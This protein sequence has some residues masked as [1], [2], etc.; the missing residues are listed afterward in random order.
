MKKR[1]FLITINWYGEVHEFWRHTSVQKDE[2]AKKRV[3]HQSIRELAKLTGYKESV[4]KSYVCD[5][6]YS[7][8]SEEEK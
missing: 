8:H 6:N 7:R 3:L 1:R 5:D 4:V 2:A